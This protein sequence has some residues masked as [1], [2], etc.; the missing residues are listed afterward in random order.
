L[1][2]SSLRIVRIVDTAFW[3]VI[4]DCGLGEA[5]LRFSVD[6]S[7]NAL[8]VSCGGSKSRPLYDDNS[9]K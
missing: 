9:I 6:L 3:L 2:S 8:F 7:R 5:I 1:A 4:S